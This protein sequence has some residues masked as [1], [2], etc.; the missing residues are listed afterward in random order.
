RGSCYPRLCRP[1]AY[2]S[3][4]D[5]SA[6]GVGLQIRRMRELIMEGSM[7]RTLLLLVASSFVLLLPQARPVQ[8]QSLRT[9]VSGVGDD[10]NPCLR[11]S[12]CKTFASAMSKTAINGE[13]NCLD[14]AALAL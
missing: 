3:C 9:F 10:A 6:N 8:A 13:I 12:P 11:T 2:L 5:L 1:L 14:P 4:A 7:R